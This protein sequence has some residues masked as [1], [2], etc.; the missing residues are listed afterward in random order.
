[1]NKLFLKYIQI[2]ARWLF[3]LCI[4][5]FLISG[6]IAVAVNSQWLYEHS[7]N[8][9]G[10]EET[11]GIETVEL[12]KAAAQII[13]YFN[14]SNEYLAIT[15]IK[16]DTDFVLFND[17]E[18]EHMK[19][20]KGLIRLDYRVL[21]FT[22]LFML[23]FILFY[24]YKD[25]NSASRMTASAVFGGASITF[26]LILI[27]G[28]MAVSDF[29]TFF[30]A[31]HLISFTNDFWLL[32]PNKDYLIMM[33]PGGFWFDAVIYIAASIAVSAVILGIGSWY[34]LRKTKADKAHSD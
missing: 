21:T 31:F 19:D 20:V 8:T 33:F 13:D 14:S 23:L 7:F 5:V 26:G 16:D 2:L 11:T 12:E 1:M 6:F 34:Y 15:V 28:I 22:G 32:D 10:V 30:T 3:I 9:Y 24:F 29:N 4:P 27:L 17:K 18:I 25:R